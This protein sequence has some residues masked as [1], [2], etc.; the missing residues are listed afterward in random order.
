MLSGIETGFFKKTLALLATASG[1][2]STR[3]F[4]DFADSD[5]HI[6]YF[7]KMGLSQ[8]PREVAFALS[9]DGAQLTIRKQSDT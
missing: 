6:H 7:Q 2:N 3:K 9:T 8:D 1:A 5:T 4:S